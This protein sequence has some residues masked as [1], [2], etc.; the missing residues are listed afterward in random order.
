MTICYTRPDLA[1]NRMKGENREG[2][3]VIQRMQT[4]YRGS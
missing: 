4:E 3:E 2:Q 1:M